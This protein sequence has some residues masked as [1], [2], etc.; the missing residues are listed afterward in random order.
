M[1]YRD[2]TPHQATEYVDEFVDNYDKANPTDQNGAAKTA[3]RPADEMLGTHGGQPSPLNSRGENFQN[4]S[5]RAYAPPERGGL[6]GQSTRASADTLNLD[7]DDYIVAYD[8]KPSDETQLY[9]VAVS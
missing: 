4:S 7:P 6:R 5:R 3:V 2:P 9:L 1:F 8:F